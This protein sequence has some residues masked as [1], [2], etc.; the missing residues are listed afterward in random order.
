MSHPA[1]VA[2][3]VVTVAMALGYVALAWYVLR[4][5]QDPS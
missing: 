1:N 3:V 5:R 4:S 2:L